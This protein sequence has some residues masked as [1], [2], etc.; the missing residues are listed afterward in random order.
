MKLLREPLLHFLLLGAALFALHGALGGRASSDGGPVV[1]IDDQLARW[2]AASQERQLGRRPTEDELRAAI[3]RHVRDEVLLEEAR[4]RGLQLG[5]T[6]IDRRLIQKMEFLLEGARTPTDAELQTYLTAH[7][8][9]YAA[10]LRVEGRH[11]FFS[12]RRPDPEGDARAALGTDDPGDPFPLGQELRGPVDRLSQELGLRMSLS[13]VQVGTWTGPLESAYGWHLV[14]LSDRVEAGPQPLAQVR[15]AVTR[16]WLIQDKEDT[17]TL[18]IEELV[19]AAH[20][21]I[22]ADLGRAVQAEP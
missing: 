5:D 20:V 3:D 11:R 1:E 6:V 8:T 21:R 7:P 12:A 2:I 10:P 19:A 9:R 13:D 22:S 18:A 4:R 15:A 16:D 14:F 17:R